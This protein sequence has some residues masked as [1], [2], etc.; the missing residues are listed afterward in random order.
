MADVC[1]GALHGDL[2]SPGG[3]GR[4]LRAELN[5]ELWDVD[6]MSRENNIPRKEEMT[7]FDPIFQLD[8]ATG[9]HR[10]MLKSLAC[11]IVRFAAA[12]KGL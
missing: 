11:A 2:A 1:V 9:I 4:R 10:D 7:H 3:D 5:I 12:L 6:F 8:L